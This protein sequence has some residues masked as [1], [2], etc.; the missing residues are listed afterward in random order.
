MVDPEGGMTGSPAIDV[1]EARRQQVVH[2][3]TL[4]AILVV[5]A[6]PRFWHLGEASLWYDEVVTMRVARAGGLA[7]MV[8]RLDRIDG[9]RAPLHPLILSVWLAVLGPSDFAGRAFSALCGLATVGVVYGIG[10]DAFD[11]RTGLWAAWL[12]AVCPPLVYYSQEVRMYAWLVL[13]T[14]SSWRVLLSFRRDAVVV[15]CVLYGVALAAL[16]YSHPLGLFMIASHGLAFLAAHRGL[17]L[18]FGRWLLIQLGVVLTLAPWLR[19]YLDHGTDYPIPRYPL[20]Y[21]LAVPI[22]YV[23]GNSLVLAVCLAI[24]A[25]GLFQLV[26]DPSTGRLRPA[27]DHP[28]ENAILVIWAVAAP[29]AMYVYSHLGQPIFGPSRYHLFIAPAYLVL[30]AHGLTRL[31]PLLRPPLAAAGLAL[32]VALL[33]GYNPTLKADWRGLAAWLDRKHPDAKAHRIVVAIHPSDPRFP[34]E[35][36]EAA[37]YYLEDRYL[38][39]AAGS[40]SEPAFGAKYDVDCLTRPHASDDDGPVRQEFHGLVVR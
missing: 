21:L 7:A 37:R 6:V 13:L 33:H 9:T 27:I 22:E 29:V 15:R 12:T 3:L 25:L 17:R 35:Q 30:L 34:R 8:E 16:G 1:T 4:A 24:V 36:V 19:R 32:S 28:V 2:S 10:R 39:V 18:G 11:R 40:G 26:R 38:V 14:A 23:G 31:P 5:A 20:K